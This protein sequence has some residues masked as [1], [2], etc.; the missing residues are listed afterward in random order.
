MRGETTK[1][2]NYIVGKS[3]GFL[4][5]GQD[6]REAEEWEVFFINSCTRHELGA[7]K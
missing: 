3:R 1:H 2:L 6:T 5:N 4:K 7:K